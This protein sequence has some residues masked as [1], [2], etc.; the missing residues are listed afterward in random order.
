MTPTKLYC[1][2]DETGQDTGDGHHV[3]FYAVGVVVT[4]HD[5]Q[6]LEKR[7]EVYEQASGKRT[8]KW[9]KTKY[10]F[11]IA[12]LHHILNDQ[13]LMGCLRVVIFGDVKKEFD[14]ATQHG[15]AQA[16][17]WNAPT[18]YTA[19]VYIDALA[20]GKRVEYRQALQK[21]GVHMGEIKGIARDESS[22]LIRLADALAGA[23]RD[24]LQDHHKEIEALFIRARNRGQLIVI[25]G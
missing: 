9:R 5:R 3:P 10:P 8:T 12:Y 11:R 22:A 18:S 7:C 25:E 20:K 23:T 17:L 6:E 15:I 24:T 13:Q 1:Y 4:A 19:Y 16:I 14:Q 21:E 2:V